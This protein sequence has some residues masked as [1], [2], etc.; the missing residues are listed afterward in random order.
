MIDIHNHILFDIDDGARSIDTSIEMCRDA[1]ENGIDTLV[2]TPHFADFKQLDA[3][4][5]ARDYKAD[6]L[7]DALKAE[8]V[9]VSIRLGA[10][11]FLSEGLLNADN[12]DELTINGS[13]Y[14]LCEFPLGPFNIKRG[15]VWLDELID[16]GY[17]PILAHPER[18]VELHKNPRIIEE[19]IDRDIVFQVNIDSLTGKNG[20][21][22]Q[23]MAVDMMHHGV[24]SLVGTD[25]H[26]T[27]FRHT[28]IKE[29]IKELPYEIDFEAF[30]KCITENAQRVLDDKEI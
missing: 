12:L 6:E 10:E 22:P 13:R 28:R 8:G 9:P 27:R 21:N 2:L 14:M 16:R 5:E 25:A 7:K 19:L 29:K 23:R 18:Y 15:L 3:F 20:P 30:E 1:Y 24:A 4:I 11:L 26:D 17:T